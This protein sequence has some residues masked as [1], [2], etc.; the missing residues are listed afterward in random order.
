MMELNI[1]PVAISYEYDPCDFLKA[2]EFQQKRDNPDFVKSQRDDLLA[3]ETGILY[4]KGRVHFTLGSPINKELAKLDR[5]MEKSELI[6]AVASAIDQRFTDITVSIR[7]TTLLTI[8]C[9]EAHDSVRI[10]DRRIRK[11]LKNTFRDSLTRL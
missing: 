2:Q 1:V 6:T 3:M 11:P 8:C 10:T 4:N 9:T 7:V 5:G